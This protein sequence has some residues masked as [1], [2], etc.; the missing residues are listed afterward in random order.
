ML[1][2]SLKGPAGNPTGVKVVGTLASE[3]GDNTSVNYAIEPGYDAANFQLNGDDLEF[4]NEVADATLNAVYYVNVSAT[5]NPK[6][7]QMVLCP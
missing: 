7:A 5:G 1:E 3:P 6:N 4:Q 2:I